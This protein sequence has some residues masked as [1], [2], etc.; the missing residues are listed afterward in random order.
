MPVQIEYTAVI[1]DFASKLA[2]MEQLN[3]TLIDSNR[4]LAR[5]AAKGSEAEV[6]M[7]AEARRAIEGLASPLDRHIR[8]LQ[9]LQRNYDAGKMSAAQ[10]SRAKAAD[11]ERYRQSTD[12]FKAGEEAKR[13][14]VSEDEKLSARGK[15]LWENSRTALERY[16]IKFKEYQ[17]LLRRGKID[18]ET[19]NRSVSAAEDE[20]AKADDAGSWM[21]GWAG[22][23]AAA[24]GAYVTV[25]GAINQVIAALEHK[26]RIE[27]ESADA[28]VTI[29][30]VQREFNANL[31]AGTDAEQQAANAAVERATAEAKPVGGL[32]AGYQVTSAALSSSGG[33]IEKAKAA[34]RVA[35][36]FS[37]TNAETAK[38]V[39]A[40]LPDVSEITKTESGEANLG[41]MMAI[42]RQAVS[43]NQQQIAQYAIP[44]AKNLTQYGFTAEQAGA[45]FTAT[46]K[47]FG[48]RDVEGR[49][50]STALGQLASQ[51]EERLPEQNVY[52]I[53]K[54]SG[55]RKLKA[56][57]TGLKTGPE[58]L[59]FLQENEEARKRFLAES[60]FETVAQIPIEELLG[61]REGKTARDY[62][63][64]LK[65]FTPR[66]Q[67]EPL[68]K[69]QLQRLNRPI[70]QQIA[71][72]QRSIDT[73]VEQ[74]QVTERLGQLGALRGVLSKENMERILKASGEG[75]IETKAAD[76]K[77]SLGE[78]AGGKAE[79]RFE[80]FGRERI[81]RL[82]TDQVVEQGYWRGDIPKVV[83]VPTTDPM[84]LEAATKL[85][86]DLAEIVAK[87]RELRQQVEAS[88][89]QK[90]QT[91]LLKDIRDGIREGNRKTPTARPAAAANVHTERGR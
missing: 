19:F 89:E 25:C 20:L 87:A 58:R 45:L 17:N 85:E 18:Q 82:R 77:F 90:Q 22:E 5:E 1:A 53:D 31:M 43:Q 29:A 28:N 8:A 52:E 30:D 3:Q 60:S 55:R 13:K 35:M 39:A 71:G 78:L 14:A 11:I 62:A 67:W 36:L 63:A 70:P 84:R 75:Y 91:D 44:A 12:A 56:K 48:Q 54:S 24:A 47:G 79:E 80:Q 9:D 65:D 27:K 41:Y 81:N 61:A 6:R 83:S 59:K 86:K 88:P 74:Q 57:G 64:N 15:Q 32:R 38:Q 66:A 23:V 2:K 40:A 69:E 37:P 50:T 33:D 68:A 73:S 21:T 7:G 10:F 72:V 46:Q 16:Q 42:G 51:M 34:A 26:R 4:R 76:F 49:L